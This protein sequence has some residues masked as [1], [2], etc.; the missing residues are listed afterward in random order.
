ME[1]WSDAK[2]NQRTF[3]PLVANTAT[4]TPGGMWYAATGAHGRHQLQN[5]V[6]DTFLPRVG[7]AYQIHP[8]TVIRGGYGLYA[9]LWSL[10]T[11]GSGEGAAFGSQGSVTDATNGV[12]PVGSLSGPNPQLPYVA[13][14]TSNSSF[15]GQGVS[16]NQQQTPVAKIQQYNIALEKQIGTDMVW[17][18]AYVGSKSSNLNFNVD[19]N[20]VPVGKLAVVDQQFRPFPQFT[21]IMGSTNNAEANYNS[22]QTTFQRRLTNNVSFAV[23]YVWSKFLDEFDSSAWGSRGGTQT[24]Q[25]AYDPHANYGPS[26]FDTRNAFK[27]S[28]IYLLPFGHGQRFL[29]QNRFADLAIGGWRL[30]STYVLQSGNP[31]TIT[32]PSTLA[33]SYTS[34][35]LYANSTGIPIRTPHTLQQW[36]NP[37]YSTAT[38]PVPGAGFAIPANGT[39][40]NMQRN[41]V[42]GPGQILFDL[43][44]GKTFDLWAERYKFQIRMDAFNALNHANFAN[45]GISLSTG[46]AGVITGTTNNGRQLQL[47]GR[48]SF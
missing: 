14:G 2:N 8:G 30:S 46:S 24:Y 23:S 13:A 36:F 12:T 40:G 15:N 34:G 21:N 6:Y 18:L 10:D 5:N 17:T 1:G 16:Y 37:A 35:N 39:F 32:V 20:Q 31:I 29:N 25:N 3:D 4:G 41:S 26:N 9:Y 43:S 44:I 11:Y 22:L 33:Q 38:A 7:F 27:G 45:P 48:F 19:T 28:A 42:V 47:G